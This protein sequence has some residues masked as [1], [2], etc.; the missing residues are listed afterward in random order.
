MLTDGCPCLWRQAAVRSSLHTE[1][2]ARAG[3]EA[4][5]TEL[6]QLVEQMREERGGWQERLRTLA[7]AELKAAEREAAEQKERAA[8]A[9]LKEVR[10]ELKELR[11]QV[12]DLEAELAAEGDARRDEAMAAGERDEC[13]AREGQA[14][15]A[16]RPALPGERSTT[17][18]DAPPCLP[19]TSVSL[20]PPPPAAAPP[21]RP[22]PAPP[23]RRG[24]LH[25]T[26]WSP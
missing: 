2:E 24:Q 14:C 8:M 9:K 22:T 4:E 13:K 15:L 10:A 25:A 16:L 12:A 21:P 17:P 3:L 26:S 19:S 6:R 7:A 11:K 23:P 20:P 18:P 1:K 5:H